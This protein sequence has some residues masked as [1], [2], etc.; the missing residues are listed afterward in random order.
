MA[1]TLEEVQV[2]QPWAPSLSKK[3]FDILNCKKR[4]ILVTGPRRTG[5]SIAVGHKICRHLWDVDDA[6]VGVF[7]TSYKVGTHGGSWSDLIDICMP[8]WL[9]SGIQSDDG[10]STFEFTSVSPSGS[11]GPKLDGKTRTPLFAI[12]NRHG[13]ESFCTLYSVD[14]ENELEAK[15][16]QLKFSMVWVVELSTF[17]SVEM[18]NMTEES[19]R[20]GPDDDQQWIADTNPSEDGT[21]SW[22]YKMFYEKRNKP[23]SEMSIDELKTFSNMTVFE[24]FQEDNPFTHPDRF[25][26]LRV[27]YAD[28]PD[29]YARHVEGRWVRASTR[30]GFVFS[31]VL[32]EDVHVIKDAIDVDKN[33]SMI[34]TGWDPGIF[35]SA[36]IAAEKRMINGIAFWFILDELVETSKEISIGD[37]AIGF[38]TKM[39]ALNEHY[40]RIWPNFHGFQWK[41]WSDPNVTTLHHPSMTGAVSAEIEN[42]T[43]GQIEL[44]AAVKG[45]GS[46]EAGC[47]FI[48]RLLREE[49]LFIGENCPHL[50]EAMRKIK[51]GGTKGD[52]IDR[53]DKLKHIIDALRYVISMESLEDL[54]ENSDGFRA[55]PSTRRLIHV[56]L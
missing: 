12:R 51:R 30:A 18:Y 26:S 11:F 49:R 14:N 29:G 19:L 8:E 28:D 54:Q 20:W 15:V 3:Q 48:R 53:N 56:R 21:S 27:K 24:V 50:L 35:N 34:Y 32:N 13:T 52:F 5:K 37:F 40:K 31:D 47:N 22:I 41:H 10:S 23:S 38:F 42:V 25:A 4:S 36:A 43:G 6:Q 46:V 55:I 16:K 7:V 1:Q 39:V 33:T 17:N 45:A 2:S 44:H 9:D